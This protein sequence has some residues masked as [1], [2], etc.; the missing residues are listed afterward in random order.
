MSGFDFSDKVMLVTGG[1]GG[2]GSA[3]CRRFAEGG[4]R[5]V[6]VDIDEIRAGKVAAELP[7]AGHRALAAT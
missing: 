4:A 5:C 3:L 2:I 6:V 1:A 7:G